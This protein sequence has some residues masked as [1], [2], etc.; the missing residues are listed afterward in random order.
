MRTFLVVLLVALA[1]LFIGC[2]GQAPA[3][4]S[5]TTTP[6]APPATTPAAPAAAAGQAPPPPPVVVATAP[7]TP[8]PA[9]DTIDLTVES[10]EGVKGGVD[11][12]GSYVPA[13][14]ANVP[15]WYQ[16]IAH[17]IDILLPAKSMVA[18][19][20]NYVGIGLNVAAYQLNQFAYPNMAGKSGD[21]VKTAIDDLGKIQT[22]MAMEKDLDPT[23]PKAAEYRT[24]IEK[25]RDA[26]RA[27][28]APAPTKKKKK[29]GPVAGELYKE[30]VK[31][32]GDMYKKKVAEG[33][34]QAKG[35][36]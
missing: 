13:D 8:P 19:D 35:K 2:Q 24:R 5:Q 28:I 10:P 22:D 1:A 31:E 36:K 30:K 18:W 16:A 25:V 17:A 34:R 27:L 23:A 29:L 9:G 21:I 26:L 7:A 14:T 11:A 4:S 33:I 3:P 15:K 32:G 12:T 6:A 20:N